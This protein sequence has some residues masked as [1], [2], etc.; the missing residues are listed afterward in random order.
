[1]NALQRNYSVATAVAVLFSAGTAP[2]QAAEGARVL[3]EIIVTS[4]KRS[5][6]LQEIPDSVTVFNQQ[7]IRSARITSIKD[8]SALTPN[9]DVSSNFRSGLNYV[10][11]RGLI[12]PQ[13]GEAPLAFV[14]DGVTV[15]SVE[16]INQGLHQIERIEVLRGPQGA[17]YGKNAI[18]GAVNIVTRRPSD[19]FAGNAQVSRAE[20]NDL[21]ASAAIGG[22]LDENLRYRLSGNYRDADGL[23][24][25][26]YLGETVDYV[27]A[28]I[29]VQAMFAYDFSEQS[30]LVVQGRYSDVTQGSNYMAFIN[31]SE[32]ENFDI[33]PDANA[34]GRDESTLWSVSAKLDHAMDYGDLTLIAGYNDA[35]VSFFSDGDFTHLPATE[36]NFF[37][38][39]TQ[40]NP[41]AEDALNF[42]ARFA[43]P[44]E[45]KLSWMAGAFYETRDRTVQ[46]DQ[47]VDN[48]PTER[49]TYK[50]IRD[51]DPELIFVGERTVQDAEA[52]AVFGN[53]SHGLTDALELAVA[54]RYDQEKREAYDERAPAESSAQET[55]SALQP[56]VSIAWQASGDV[57]LSATWS[58][59]FRS[60]G[61]NEYAPTVQRF[62]DKEISDTFEMSAKTTW[63]DGTLLLNAALFYI[64]QEDAQFTRFNST[65]FTLENLNVDAVEILGFELEMVA[66]VTENLRFLMGVGILNNE[67]VKNTGIDT[68]TGTDLV[69]TEGNAM[70][71]VSDYNINASLNHVLPLSNGLSLNSRL[72]FNSI[73][74][75]SFD[76]SKELTGTSDSHT[77]VNGSVELGG[78]TWSISLFASNLL[79][80]E[81]PETVFNF[82]PLIRF[83]NQPRQVGI[84]V[85]L[86][87]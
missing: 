56:K 63:L 17:L 87:F 29:G 85:G 40:R 21:R 2:V 35:D 3:E 57:L 9:L 28:E 43:S 72:A 10:T 18:G 36:K 32:L 86:Q 50:D 53:V 82:N 13:V 19:E 26:P 41:I 22:S 51:V 6:N 70:P 48:T 37:F 65:T 11:I 52:F 31:Q 5:E 67:I 76:V 38:P 23:L 12:T 4:R 71:Y 64:E 16:F 69:L 15:P 7:Q 75:R 59:G 83:P 80:E 55:Y 24:D 44:R 20:G 79:D 30:S 39:T 54:L 14:V 78:D 34:V 33:K 27:D 58:R 81:M 74:P 68:L 8:F 77:F 46:F 66:L 42:E 1:M 45:Q 62:Y 60:G 61:F 49:V 84:Q 47:I 25:N 73:G